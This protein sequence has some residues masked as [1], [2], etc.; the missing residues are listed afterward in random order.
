MP[1]ICTKNCLQTPS[2]NYNRHGEEQQ[3][4]VR[5]QPWALSL[6]DQ[7]REFIC[8]RSDGPDQSFSTDGQLYSQAAFSLRFTQK[9]MQTAQRTP[10]AFTAL[11]DAQKLKE[12]LLKD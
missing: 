12:N 1:A 11:D 2:H 4:C 6:V 10:L 9:C 5:S 8:S 3:M 7:R